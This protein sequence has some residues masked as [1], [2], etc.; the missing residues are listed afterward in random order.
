MSEREFVHEFGCWWE[1]TASG[2]REP[3]SADEVGRAI[4][5]VRS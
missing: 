1:I 5:Q 4:A 2:K 3:V